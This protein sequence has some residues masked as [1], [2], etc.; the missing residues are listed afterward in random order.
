MKQELWPPFNDPDSEL[1]CPRALLV[2]AMV[3]TVRLYARDAGLHYLDAGL[4]LARA[5][6]RVAYGENESVAAVQTDVG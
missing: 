6:R 5:E 1:F 4:I 3:Y 2:G